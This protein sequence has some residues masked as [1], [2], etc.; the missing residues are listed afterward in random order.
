M[1]AN[2]TCSAALEASLPEDMLPLLDFAKRHGVF[3]FHYED[4]IGSTNDLAHALFESGCPNGLVVLANGQS[5]GRGSKG[6]QW[7][8][9]YGL[10]IYMT[11]VLRPEGLQIS[12]ASIINLMASLTVARAINMFTGLSAWPKWP[13]DI[14][15]SGK[16]IAG[17]LCESIISNGYVKGLFIGIGV[18]VNQRTFPANLTDSASSVF[19]QTGI[20]HERGGLIIDILNMFRMYYR[21]LLSKDSQ[22]IIDRWSDMSKTINAKVCINSLTVKYS[23]TVIGVDSV[24]RLVIKSDSGELSTVLEGEVSHVISH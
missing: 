14:Y 5:S 24:G 22:L 6:R 21:L 1:S 8:S 19:L 16:K 2:P 18:N 17:I 15:V 9:P 7:Y 10:N 20:A 3:S 13:N 23:G 4:T 12:K 11:I